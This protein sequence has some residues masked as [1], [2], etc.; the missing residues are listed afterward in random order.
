M[1]NDI[2]LWIK[3]QWKRMPVECQ[4]RYSKR[5]EIWKRTMVIHWSWFWKEVVLYQWRQ[6]TRRMGPYGGKDVSGI[7]RKWMSNFPRH[8]PIVQRSTQKQRTRK[9]VNSLCCRPRNNWDYFS[10]DCF[11]K[12]AQSLRSSRRDVRRVQNPSRQIGATR[13]GRAVEFLIRAK[14]DQDRSA[15]GLWWPCSLR[16]STATIWRTNWKV[17]TTRQIEQI[18]YGC[19]IYKCWL[20]WT[21]FH[22]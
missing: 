6:S 5:K 15:F 17:I 2:F 22:D 12:S 16:S 4:S 20:N 14:R 21:V 9:T 8:E 19:R 1:F 7:R 10:H 11:C 13:C 18:L 3:R